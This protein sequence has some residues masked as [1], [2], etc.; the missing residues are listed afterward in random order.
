MYLYKCIGKHLY[1]YIFF[2]VNMFFQS[3]FYQI[4]KRSSQIFLV[5]RN[6][7]RENMPQFIIWEQFNPKTKPE[8]YGCLLWNEILRTVTGWRGS[9]EMSWTQLQRL[10]CCCAGRCVTMNQC[11]LWRSKCMFVIS[12]AWP[13]GSSTKKA[14][15]TETLKKVTFISSPLVRILPRKT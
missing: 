13:P 8:N 3:K 15:W 2:F 5:S 14:V 9:Q 7:E 11:N 10:W 12:E 1:I 4:F 6:Q